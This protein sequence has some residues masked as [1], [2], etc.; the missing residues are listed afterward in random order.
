MKESC[1]IKGLQWTGREKYN[2]N[3]G[4]GSSHETLLD[5]D[6]H[7]LIRT[8]ASLFYILTSMESRRLSE[9]KKK[10]ERIC[11]FAGMSGFE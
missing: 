6:S 2:S 1:E 9:N 5:P 3:V 4:T 11:M 10:V 7:E 8:L